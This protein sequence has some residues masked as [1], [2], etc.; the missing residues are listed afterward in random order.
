MPIY[1]VSCIYFN[2]HLQLSFTMLFART[3]KDAT[4]FSFFQ[5][6][7]LTDIVT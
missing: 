1:L 5:D 7:S 2:Y 6:R 3:Y 4:A